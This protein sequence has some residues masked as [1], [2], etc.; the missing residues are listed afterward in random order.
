MLR[1]R[2]AMR[3][4]SHPPVDEDLPLLDVKIPADQVL[5]GGLARAGRADKGHPLA[6]LHGKG[7]VP[8]DPFLVPVGEPDVFEPMRPWK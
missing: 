6:G 2:S 4:F 7:H 3:I 8:E 1:R 5:D